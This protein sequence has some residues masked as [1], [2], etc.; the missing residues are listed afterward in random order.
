MVN[1]DIGALF[2]A[3][4]DN[5]QLRLT[6]TIVMPNDALVNHINETLNATNMT[7][8]PGTS[9]SRSLSGKDKTVEQ[10]MESLDLNKV[11]KAGPFLEDCKIFLSGFTDSE[12]DFLDKVIAAA[13]GHRMN[14]LTASVTHFVAARSNQDH[15]RV[16][17]NLGLSPYK[18]SLQWMVESML[19]GQPVPESDF[20]LQT[21][22]TR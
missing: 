1:L 5:V 15:F 10:L 6:T 2:L 18:V 11:R 14:Q 20:P 19:M 7:V 13:N 4:L 8:M 22:E 3:G 12:A 9:S 17:T 21:E 16:M